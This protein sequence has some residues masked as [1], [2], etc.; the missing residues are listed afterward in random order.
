MSSLY[1]FKSIQNVHTSA[2]LIDIVL[3]KTQR[4]T[5]TEVHPGYQISRIR[6]FYMRKVKYSAETFKEKLSGIL[7]TFPKLDDIHPFFADLL[8]ILYDKDHYKIALGQT[9][10]VKSI[11]DKI[12]KDYVK[13]LK[14]ADSMYRAK[15]LKIAAMGRM[16]TAIK[17]LKPSLE[18]LEEVRKHL[19][20]LPIIDPFLPSVLLFGYPNVGKSSFMNEVTKAD[21]DISEIPFSTQN[22]FVG[23]STFK[24]VKIQFIDSP[25][26]LDRALEQRNTIEMQSITAL[27]HLKAMI[28]FMV[29]I[30]ENCGYSIQDQI[31]L[32]ES[33]KPLFTTK[34]T[35]LVLTKVDLQKYEDL[36]QEQRD[37]IEDFQKRY[38]EVELKKL[39]S[40]DEKLVEQLRGSAC[41]KLMDYRTEN[42]KFNDGMNKLKTDED[43]YYG[44]RVFEPTQ[45]R[46]GQ[47]QRKAFIPDSVL[48]ERKLAEK[49]KRKTLKDMQEE[50][51]GAGVFSFPWN[52]HF[53]LENPD[54][55]YDIPPEI[56]DGTNIID[57]VDPDI[58][59]KILELEKEQEGLVI[60]D[61]E[62]IDEME[63]EENETLVQ[64]RQSKYVN[65]LDGRLK[66]NKATSKNRIKVSSLKQKLANKGKK[67]EKFEKRAARKFEN[68]KRLEMKK[69]M[70]N[71]NVEDR[72][73]KVKNR[74]TERGMWNTLDQKTEK[75]RRKIQKRVLTQGQKGD[76][77]RHVYDLKPKHLN[78]GKRGIGS[79][80]RR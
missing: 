49:P 17:K 76:S 68:Q 21:V 59:R 7:D 58:E 65:Q 29:D 6:A 72:V 70:K 43:Y 13:L 54:W 30:S 41:Q 23:H 79:N 47:Q 12:A 31:A 64:V 34:P 56:M 18:Y 36:D 73:A 78:S 14:Y 26:V 80:D 46:E 71:M 38:P 15:T 8:N 74:K 25:G 42:K 55:K 2:D 40:L 44:V 32:F 39:S 63:M 9:N 28:V 53:L 1:I 60:P 51:G 77:D 35:Y 61:E 20:R 10:V 37:C 50:H 62:I 75:R 11:I 69:M 52:E 24:N 22:L 48:K 16:C 3:S 45:K 27:A 19:S 67:S 57:Y 4:K 66:K 5:P 33:L